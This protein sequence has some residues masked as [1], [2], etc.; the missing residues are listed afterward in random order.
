MAC[1]LSYPRL[2]R[3]YQIPEHPLETE[4]VLVPGIREAV[5]AWRQGGY[6]GATATSVALL[7]H[8][9]ETDHE[10]GDYPWLY[11]YCQREAVETTVLLY[12]VLRKRRLYDL[13]GEF[14][15]Q[16]MEVQVRVSADRWCRYAYKMATGSGKTKVISLLI[17]W[18]Y[19]NAVREAPEVS[20]D[21]AKTF[22]VLAPNVIVYERLLQDFGNDGKIFRDDPVRPPSWE[23]DWNFDIVTRD[24]PT[25]SAYK[26]GAIFVTNIQQMYT[27]RPPRTLEPQ[28]LRDLLGEPVT[29]S[30]VSAGVK[31]R[32]AIEKR[33]DLMVF[34]DEGHHLHDPKLKWSE[35]IDDF[36]AGFKTRRGVGIK[37]Q[38]DFS[39]TPKHNDGRLFDNIIVDYPIRQAIRDGVVKVPHLVTLENARDLQVDDAGERY[40]DKLLAGIRHFG[41]M[42][43]RM[44]GVDAQPLMFVMTED[45]KSA[46]QVASWL[47]RQGHFRANEILTIHTKQDGTVSDTASNANELQLLRRAAREVD[48]PMSPYKVI[49]SVLMLREGWDVKNV[50]L[51]VPLRPYSAASQILPE[52]TLGRGLRRMFPIGSGDEREELL[53]VD[54]ESFAEFWRHEVGEEDLPLQVTRESDFKQTTTVVAPDPEKAPEFE[55]AIPRLSPVLVRE[56]PDLNELKI[57]ELVVRRFAVALEG[58]ADEPIHYAVRDMD[59]WEVVG[60]GDIERDFSMDPVGYLNFVCDLILRECRLRG[61]SDGFAKL[62]PKVRRYVEEIGFAGQ[63]TLGE[64]HALLALSDPSTTN[65][66]LDAFVR[67]I[68]ELAVKQHKVADVQDPILV[69]RTRPFVTRRQTFPNPRRS[70]F[71]HVPGDSDLELDFARWLDRRA[72]DVAAFVKNESA[73][74]FRLEYLSDRGGIRHYYPDFVVRLTDGDMMV[75]ETKGLETVEVARK[76]DRVAQWCRDVSVLS[77]RN[78][79][80]LKVEERVFRQ[81]LDWS[82]VSQL[83]RAARDRA[84]ADP[85]N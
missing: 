30:D 15:Q 25:E 54:H 11:Y 22:L 56:M 28:P 47:Q 5:N 21:Y 16:R 33:N 12:E 26:E 45:T 49:V 77:G 41:E 43:E 52:Q 70:V 73:V 8:W 57:E 48:S 13:V 44:R 69:S 82:S 35:T 58:L 61:L 68:N 59:S 31:M 7:R 62:A 80:Y 53:I 32:A 46:D 24:N 78:W 55:V 64:S 81:G 2:Q 19:Y 76:D 75:I 51:I 9:F 65:A 36:S 29:D 20:K 3:A 60:R 74:G 71:N 66:I 67:G 10:V 23:D 72:N 37:A 27:P 18:S 85:S 4:A 14:A 50:C 6:P 38:F 34:N 1:E 84:N 79:Y 17:A 83:A 40:R 39:A 63:A 42:C